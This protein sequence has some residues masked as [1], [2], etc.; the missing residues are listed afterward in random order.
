M[1]VLSMIYVDK[2]SGKKFDRPRYTVLR[3]D[4][5]RAG[6]TLIITEMD[7][8]GRNKQQIL[9][10]LEYFKNKK[11]RV[12]ILEIPTSTMDIDINNPLYGLFM[13]AIQNL[14]IE[15]FAILSEAEIIKKEKRQK[16]GIE[17]MKL[18]GEWD[19]YGR[20]HAVEWERF[21]EVYKSVLSEELK[22]F[23]AI[24]QLGISTQTYYRY[25]KQYHV[26]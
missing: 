7:R 14:I 15:L 25:K 8:L 16:E 12:M 13:E 11:V 22:P 19:K 1:T 3:E 23:E 5:L 21:V 20:P 26:A 17:A 4:V 18:R 24:R 6:D 2:M 10:E 9:K